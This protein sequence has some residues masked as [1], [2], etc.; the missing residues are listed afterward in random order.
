[1]FKETD[2]FNTANPVKVYKMYI[3]YEVARLFLDFSYE[4]SNFSSASSLFTY[5]KA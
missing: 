1:V 5:T 4:E 3:N 2:Y